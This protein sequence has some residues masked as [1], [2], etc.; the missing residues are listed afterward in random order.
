ML[1]VADK[2]HVRKGSRDWYFRRVAPNGRTLN[3]G[4]GYNSEDLAIEGALRANPDLGR[5]DIVMAKKSEAPQQDNDG[6]V[7]QTQP[8][9]R[10]NVY[11]A[12][13]GEGIENYSEP[14]AEERAKV[15]ATNQGLATGGVHLADE[16]GELTGSGQHLVDTVS[17]AS[18]EGVEIVG[19][20]G[21]GPYG[22]PKT[23]EEGKVAEDQ[24]ARS[25]AKK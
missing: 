24:R 6:V 7:T 18:G 21:S 2:L 11:E 9:D 19:G 14:S 22:Q 8:S 12:E 4:R 15:N 5:K 10:R 1:G 25:T 20:H 17:A 23:A 13:P 3:G 16:A